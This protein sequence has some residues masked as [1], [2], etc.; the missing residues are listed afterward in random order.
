M[1]DHLEFWKMNTKILKCSFTNYPSIVSNCCSLQ[2]FER[3]G[4]TFLFE[5]QRDK[6]FLYILLY[7]YYTL[8]NS[9]KILITPTNLQTSLIFLYV[10]SPALA[11]FFFFFSYNTESRFSYWH[12]KEIWHYIQYAKVRMKKKKMIKR[13][14]VKS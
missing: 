5:R 7:V 6:P 1:H 4:G 2:I 9:L 11:F 13:R 14:S 12:S 3:E 8:F 10:S